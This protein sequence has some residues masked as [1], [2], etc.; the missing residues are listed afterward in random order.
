MKTKKYYNIEKMRVIAAIMV[1]IIH[2][3]AFIFYDNQATYKNYYFYRYIM[4]F[5]V[6]YFFALIGFF[7]SK[8]KN[9]NKVLKQI[10]K[11]LNIYIWASMAM[12]VLNFLVV[13]LKKLLFNQ[14]LIPQLKN[15]LTNILQWF[16]ILN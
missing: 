9:H 16:S 2:A 1:I 15:I 13:V 12:V 3:T 10:K 8:H 5:A 7:M 14:A 11:Y 6:S 4:D